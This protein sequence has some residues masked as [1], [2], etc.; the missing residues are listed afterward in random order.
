[1]TYEIAMQREITTELST[2]GRMRVWSHEVFTLEDPPRE[3]KVAGI[4]RIPAGSYELRLNILGGMNQRYQQRFPNMHEGMIELLEVPMF[5]WVYIHIGNKPK[6]TEGCIL[7]GTARSDDYIVSSAA[8]YKR[9]YPLIVDAI[10]SGGC[11]I[12]IHDESEMAF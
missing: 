1:M 2:I 7:V 3:H 9:I 12:T 8:A 6:D 11:K 4:T 5:E 10:R